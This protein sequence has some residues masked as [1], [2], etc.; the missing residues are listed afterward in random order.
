MGRLLG[1][2]VLRDGHRQ[3]AQLTTFYPHVDERQLVLWSRWLHEYR[4]LGLASAEYVSLYDLAFDLPALPVARKV[5]E[6][7][8]GIFLDFCLRK[9]RIELRGLD[10]D[11]MY[12]V[13]DHSSRKSLG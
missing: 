4:S 2:L 11:T 13:Y 12:E 10:K 8:Y 1:A 3:G 6:M 7:Y 9:K 5:K